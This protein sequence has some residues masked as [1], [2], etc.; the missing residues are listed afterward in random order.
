MEPASR[1]GSRTPAA[2]PPGDA[3]GGPESGDLRR[4]QW[5]RP[6]KEALAKA[7]QTN[8]VLL[9]KPLMGGS[10]VPDETGVPCG[11]KRDCEGSW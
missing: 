8:R 9:V 11:G 2:A 1:P 3:R 5:V 10:N 6:F 4:V 7:R